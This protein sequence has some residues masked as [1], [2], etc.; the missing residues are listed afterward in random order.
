MSKCKDGPL[1]SLVLLVVTIAVLAFAAVFTACT[2]DDPYTWGELSLD[3][4]K[5][6]CAAS[7]GCG[8]D[9]KPHCAEHVQWH[10]CVPN[11][12]CDVALPDEAH[13]AM[14]VCAAR[15]DAATDEDC[16]LLFYGYL[17][18]ECDLVFSFDP[19]PQP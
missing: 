2:D 4:G 12:S 11:E 14:D 15:L 1:A 6:Y 19:G 3:L 7:S 8:F 5:S 18:V 13:V 17:P 10:E 16:V 9:V